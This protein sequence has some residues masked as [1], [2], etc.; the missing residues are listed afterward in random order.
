MRQLYTPVAPCPRLSLGSTDSPPFFRTD[1]AYRAE[2]IDVI[3][4][5]RG[6]DNRRTHPGSTVASPAV[7]PHANALGV[8][9]PS[10]T[11]DEKRMPANT[12]GCN[13][14][15]ISAAPGLEMSSPAYNRQR[16]SR[17]GNQRRTPVSGSVRGWGGSRA[18]APD[19]PSLFDRTSGVPIT[20]GIEKYSSMRIGGRLFQ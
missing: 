14:S 19:G 9:A 18:V 3:A 16:G 15:T 20:I 5:Q 12:V 6:R 7:V 1:R 17:T 13:R 8:T 11:G 10:E 2:G 4:R